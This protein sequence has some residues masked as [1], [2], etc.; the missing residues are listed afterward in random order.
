VS[1]SQLDRHFVAPGDFIVDR[2]DGGGLFSR[3]WGDQAASLR[4]INAPLLWEG[5]QA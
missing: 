1:E 5:D 2:C 3:P 4:R